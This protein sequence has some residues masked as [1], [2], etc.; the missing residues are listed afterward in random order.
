[1]LDAVP[2][3]S[4]SRTLKFYPTTYLF[5]VTRNLMHGRYQISVTVVLGGY[6]SLAPSPVRMVSSSMRFGFDF[7]W[8]QNQAPVGFERMVASLH[9][10]EAL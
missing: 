4:L 2:H 5:S 9:P 7:T 6:G 10:I 8:S 3:I 1:M